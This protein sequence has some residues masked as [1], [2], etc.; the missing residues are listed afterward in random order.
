MNEWGH[1]LGSGLA[2]AVEQALNQAL[3]R[4]PASFK[5]LQALLDAPFQLQFDPPGLSLYLS[6]DSRALRVQW[7]CEMA[8]ALVLSGSP[9]GFAA[10]ALGDDSV[11]RDGRIR[12][13]GD[14]AR[15]QRLQQILQQ[16]EPDWEASLAEVIGG[17]P[18][19][20]VARRLRQGLNWSREA[21]AVLARNLE[22]YLQEES[23]TLP[24]RA[25]AEALFDDIDAL[26]LDADRL[27]ARLSLLEKAL[28]EKAD[29]DSQRPSEP[30]PDGESP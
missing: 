14:V 7:A 22:E 19:H 15:A 6:A 30:P 11:F 23:D 1:T 13:T 21:R 3:A 27:A 8:P 12:L 24:A 26:R 25:E 10:A 17:V 5:A 28:L 20:F 2:A 18:A 16:L 29:Q 9:L 4:D